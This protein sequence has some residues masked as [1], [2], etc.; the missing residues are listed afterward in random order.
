MKH[1]VIL[2]VLFYSA[3]CFTQDFPVSHDI[4]D[5]LDIGTIVFGDIGLAGYDLSRA[6]D[7]L[8]KNGVRYSPNGNVKWS[9]DFSLGFKSKI[10]KDNIYFGLDFTFPTETTDRNAYFQDENQS[11]SNYWTSYWC[12]LSRWYL[13]FSLSN[14]LYKSDNIIIMN[15]VGISPGVYKISVLRDF[16]SDTIVFHNNFKDELDYPNNFR[17]EQTTLHYTVKGSIGI[18]SYFDLIR[19]R[20]SNSKIQTEQSNSVFLQ[21]RFEIWFGGYINY[22][23]IFYNYS[24]DYYGREGLSFSPPLFQYGLRLM[25]TMPYRYIVVR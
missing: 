22:N 17:T 2:I 24:P 23:P 7:F 20:L 15:S 21:R 3:P 6:E 4:E 16:D 11:N 12:H 19:I 14:I 18:E 1:L 5:S 9:P 10:R 25:C 13:N 8:A